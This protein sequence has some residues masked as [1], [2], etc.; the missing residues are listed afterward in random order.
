MFAGSF[1]RI[2]PDFFSKKMATHFSGKI[3]YRNFPENP[4][5]NYRQ[6]FSDIIAKI[7]QV[8]SYSI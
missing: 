1:S 2:V 3:F 5:R 7:P 6:F 8:K 4:G